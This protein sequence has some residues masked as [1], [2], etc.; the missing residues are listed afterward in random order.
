MH[1][2]I[3]KTTKSGQ[4][5]TETQLLP[6]LGANTEAF[7]NHIVCSEED[8]VRGMG[9]VPPEE[10][11]K[12]DATEIPKLNSVSECHMAGGL[13]GPTAW[14]SRESLTTPSRWR[15]LSHVPL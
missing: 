9:E 7:L 10:F 5:T 8:A 2:F 14:R 12:A 1:S 11:C 4:R 3:E 6:S 13:L 15:N